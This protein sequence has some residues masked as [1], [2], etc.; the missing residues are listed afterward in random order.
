MATTVALQLTDGKEHTV[1]DV[2]RVSK[3]LMDA[4]TRQGADVVRAPGLITNDDVR[5]IRRYVNTGLELPTTLEEVSQL[6]GGQDNGIPGLGAA[7]IAELYV[8]IQAHA[9]SWSEVET[10]MQKVGSDLYV[11]SGN[12]IT[13]ATNVVDFI[14]GLES[15]QTLQVG[16]LS[17]SQIDEMP[18]V[19]LMD[20]DSRKLPGLLSLVDELK[21]YIKEH[22]ASTTRT[23]VGVTDFKRRLQENIAPGVALKIRLAGSVSGDEEIA[24]LVADVDQLNRRINQKLAEYEEYSEYKWIG[25]WWGPVGGAVSL[26]IFGPKASMALA[27]KDHLIGEKRQIEQKIKQFNALLSDLLAFETS[28]QDLKARVSGAASGVSNIESL[29]VLLEELVDSSYDRI[30]NTNNALYLVS[31]VSRFQTLMSNW[32]EIQVQAFDLLTA[33]NNVLDEPVV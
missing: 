23:R 10:A 33:F 13:I 14:K 15:Y 5:R 11:F 4:L 28:L 3:D 8:A 25:F 21:V 18:P 22:S 6:T 20:Q 17:P 1:E 32:K 16:D 12:L 26:S 19:A 31:F 27:E 29:W 30:K 24:R 2:S 9:R 7:A